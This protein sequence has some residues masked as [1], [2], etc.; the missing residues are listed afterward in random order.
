MDWPAYQ[1]NTAST[2]AG[3]RNKINNILLLTIRKNPQH[4]Q[5]VLNL[6]LP[7]HSNSLTI[8][9][10]TC[11]LFLHST[12]LCSIQASSEPYFSINGSEAYP[13]LHPAVQRLPQVQAPLAF[14]PSTANCSTSPQVTRL[15]N[16]FSGAASD[17]SI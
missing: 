6:C 3:K 2:Y 4:L 13:I 1:E 11:F 16:S 14:A 9:L 8:A 15:K 7:P 10:L 5:C 17:I 12:Q